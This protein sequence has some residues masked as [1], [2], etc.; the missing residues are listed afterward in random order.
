MEGW[1]CTR[2][3]VPTKS[4]LLLCPPVP[5]QLMVQAVRKRAENPEQALKHR[6]QYACA[7]S[8]VYQIIH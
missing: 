6:G 5:H 2:C 1:T 3:H 4:G 8:P 7:C